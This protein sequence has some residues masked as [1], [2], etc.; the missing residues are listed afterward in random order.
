M[1]SAAAIDQKNT[2]MKAN[3]SMPNTF[4]SFMIKIIKQYFTYCIFFL[5]YKVHHRRRHRP[6]V[7]TC[8]RRNEKISILN[9]K[10][11]SLLMIKEILQSEN[12]ALRKELKHLNDR[13]SESNCKYQQ[14]LRKRLLQEADLY[15]EKLE[16]QRIASQKQVM[17]ANAHVEHMS[18]ANFPLPRKSLM[19][20]SPI[21]KFHSLA[22]ATISNNS[23]LGHVV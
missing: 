1:K 18:L 5:A 2:T 8:Y 23:K 9:R 17:L 6:M 19:T 21:T 4:C 20:Q 14:L 13:V 7:Y 3:K 22:E 11:I 16:K 15:K 10:C 12:I